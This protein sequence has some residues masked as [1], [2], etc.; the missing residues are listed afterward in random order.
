MNVRFKYITKR[1]YFDNTSPCF[2]NLKE[3]NLS[4]NNIGD[5]GMRHLSEALQAQPTAFQN[6]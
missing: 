2:Q 1:F 3:L 6:S 4:F 5:E